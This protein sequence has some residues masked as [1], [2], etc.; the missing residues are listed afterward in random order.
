MGTLLGAKG[1]PS[2]MAGPLQHRFGT[3]PPR[4]ELPLSASEHPEPLQNSKTRS[5]TPRVPE[6]L[7]A[8]L[9][10]LSAVTGTPPPVPD[11]SA[12]PDA[13]LG[14]LSPR[15]GLPISA[16]EH[17]QPLQNSKTRSGTPGGPERVAACRDGRVPARPKAAPEC[18]PSRIGKNP[19][20]NASH[21][22][23]PKPVP[24]CQPS[25]IAKTR[26]GTPRVP[27]RVTVYWI[28]SCSKMAFSIRAQLYPFGT[29][30]SA[31]AQVLRLPKGSKKRA[32]YNN[33]NLY[34]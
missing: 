13:G 3:P 30:E 18:Q 23:S 2:P 32:I 9:A 28:A 16:S 25:R 22:E 34:L 12:F 8:I 31:M 19:F 5:W 6:R 11:H 20:R 26:S 21:P 14:H 29:G 10:R 7:S 33:L 4:S 27:K 24:E 1:D 15:S 17:P